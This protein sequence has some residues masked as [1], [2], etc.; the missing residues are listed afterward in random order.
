MS[1]AS[2][3]MKEKR[4]PKIILFKIFAIQTSSFHTQNW[5]NV[6]TVFITWKP[7]E[8]KFRKFVEKKER[9]HWI[10]S[11]FWSVVWISNYEERPKVIVK[12]STASFVK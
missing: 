10:S 1:D 11:V 5:I 2:Y 6:L 3:E 7:T 8:N 9:V 4:L 12:F